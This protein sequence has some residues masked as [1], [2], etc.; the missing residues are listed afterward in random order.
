MKAAIITIG[1]ELVQGFTHDT[2]SF[3]ISNTLTKY[4]IKVVKIISVGD[5]YKDITNAF[6][7]LLNLYTLDYIFITG[8]LGPTHDDIT[9]NVLSKYLKLKIK[10]DHIYLK[11]LKKK[12]K[13]NNITLPSNLVSQASILENATPINNDNGSALGL[14]IEKNNT[15]I[16]VLPG[17]PSE[18]KYMFKTKIISTYI[19]NALSSKYITI[20]TAGIYE[21]KLFNILADVI[22]KYKNK[23]KVAF[24]PKYTGVNI[25]IS[26]LNDD[27][28]NSEF[29][30]FENT[31]KDRIERYI[32]SV[33]N[34][35]LEEVV[36][37][38]L[39]DRNMKLSVAE[40]CTGGLIAKKLT[41]IPGSSKF[42]LGGVVAYDNKLKEKLLNISKFDLN[43]YGAVSE[44]IS[45]Q[46]V[47][48][49][50]KITNSDIA[51]ATT[52]ISGPT[53]GTK[54]K[55]IG[56]VYI[57]IIYNDQLLIKKFNLIPERNAHR[58]ITTSVALNIIRY[59]LK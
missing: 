36:G 31:L 8:G 53:G 58:E 35:T 55:P 7:N 23:Y 33:N 54:E 44:E 38:I 32:Y 3:W 13:N 59:L 5:N 6:D 57:S 14:M 48:G 28:E 46:M 45:K 51:L 26:K 18:M 49:I 37:K 42:F 29:K 2:N 25:R 47:E 1:D 15:K 4:S 27:I 19:S 39:L 12:Y 34:E 21:S 41:D 17:V 22:E 30:K 43:K 11:N 56:L 9:K 52:G 40:S 24:L 20:S 16:F 10:I 50:K